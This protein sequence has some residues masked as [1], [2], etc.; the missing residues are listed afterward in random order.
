MD[1]NRMCMAD[2]VVGAADE[3]GVEFG[4]ATGAVEIGLLESSSSDAFL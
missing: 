2:K 1:G 4:W 3:A